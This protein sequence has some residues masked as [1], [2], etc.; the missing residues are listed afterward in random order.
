MEQL[1]HPLSDLVHLV[2]L[3][4]VVDRY[5]CV[6]VVTVTSLS[7]NLSFPANS[8]TCKEHI[9]YIATKLKESY[10]ILT[11]WCRCWAAYDRTVHE[12]LILCPCR[13]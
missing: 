4:I 6:E 12:A 1:E 3:E 11:L 5:R 8:L 13:C 9:N 2:R 10:N 7:W